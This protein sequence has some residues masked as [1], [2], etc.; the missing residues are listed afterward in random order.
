MSNDKTTTSLYVDE[1]T[2]NEFADNCETVGENTSSM[3]K[4]LMKDFNQSQQGDLAVVEAEISKLEDEVEELEDEVSRK[5]SRLD[6]LRGKRDELEQE[7][8]TFDEL[9]QELA[10]KK[11][12]GLTIVTLPQFEAAQ[13]T[14]KVSATELEEIVEDRVGDVEDNEE[15]EIDIEAMLSGDAGDSK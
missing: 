4:Q 7:L 3:M 1:E 2:L 12:S 10:E 6:L 15:D 13:E 11:S 5:Q 14:G 8:T 9:V